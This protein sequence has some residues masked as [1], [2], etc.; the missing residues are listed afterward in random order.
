MKP[1]FTNA[2]NSRLMNVNEIV[3]MFNFVDNASYVEKNN[4][5]YGLIDSLL[6]L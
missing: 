2:D 1:S 4:V 5:I 6:L 3:K